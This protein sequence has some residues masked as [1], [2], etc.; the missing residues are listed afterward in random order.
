MFLIRPGVWDAACMRYRGY[1]VVEALRLSGIEVAYIDD[2]HLTERFAEVLSYDLIVLVRRPMTPEMSELLDA[3]AELSVPVVFDL[4]DYLF[5]DEI[6]PYVAM[7]RLAS[8]EKARAGVAEW[9]D[10]LMRCDFYTGSTAYLTERA[11]AIGREAFL[12]RN[13]LNDAQLELSR[14]ALEQ[15]R[16]KPSRSGPRLG[17]FSGT[18]THQDDFRQI[19]TVLVRLLGEFP[20]LELVVTGDFDLTEFPEFGPFADR[21]EERP[22]V[23]WRRLPA[24][25]ARVDINLIPL[26]VNTFTEGKSNLKYYEAALLHVPSVATPSS[27]F[28]SSIE[29]GVT[30][31]L[32]QTDDEWYESL[33]ALIVDPKLLRDM[34]ERAY[35]DAL[36]EYSPRVVAGEA[37]SAYRQMLTSHRRRLGVPDQAPTIVVLVSD[38]DRAIQGRD[39]V[40]SMTRELSTLG[41]VV[42]LQVCDGA[43]GLSAEEAGRKIAELVGETTF[44]IELGA[45]IPCCDVLLATDPITAQ[46]A[47]RAEGRAIYVAYSVAEY[48]PARLSAGPDRDR[49]DASYG[50]GL[51]L[52]TYDAAV[53][54]QLERRHG[55]RTTI[56]SPW[57]ERAYRPL[58]CFDPRT[59]L[60]IATGPLPEHVWCEAIDALG[61]VHA[62]HPDVTIVL[63]GEASSLSPRCGFPHTVLPDLVG[64]AFETQLEQ[65]PIVLVLQPSGTPRWMYDL[66]AAGCPVV[67]LL[68][69]WGPP[70]TRAELVE[71]YLSVGVEGRAMADAI[72]SLVVDRGRLGR[73]LFRASE[74]V[75]N[76]G[77]A[78]ETADAFLRGMEL[79]DSQRHQDVCGTSGP[80][81]HVA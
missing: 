54:E 45:E 74:R 26:E 50:W 7:L 72:E 4:D 56:L 79:A 18:R 16:R 25:I 38:L 67:A 23:D 48:L 70:G 61:R 34:G 11:T 32:A 8:P 5:D 80:F 60:A 17:Y 62:H 75:Q 66:M 51:D 35:R 21:L 76:L 73:L 64:P 29:H 40:L 41:A 39:P 10:M 47:K 49:A 65:R 81:A 42:T 57:V 78:N 37:L 71:G 13:G 3:A 52:I 9:R 63:G 24:E 43:S 77:N 6:I 28:A 27:A 36:R 44:A 33:R 12:I 2:R 55:A 14:I 19:A 69:E 53:A 15:V 20:T 46:L 22:F 30:G 59:V 31:Y 68:D 1:N 58:E